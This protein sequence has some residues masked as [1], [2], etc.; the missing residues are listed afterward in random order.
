LHM[1]LEEKDFRYFQHQIHRDNL[2]EDMLH[3]MCVVTQNLPF[4]FLTY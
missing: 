3:Y 2:M 4:P 1:G